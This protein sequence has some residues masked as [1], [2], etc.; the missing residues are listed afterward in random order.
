MATNIALAAVKIAAGVLGS[1][2]AL[3]ADGVESSV[4][5]LSSFAVWN[6]LRIAAWPPDEDHPYGHGKAESIAGLVTALTLMAAAVAIAWESLREIFTPH[7]S[8]APFTLIVLMAVIAIKTALSR[9]VKNVGADIDSSALK[10][11]AA[12][13][14]SD[15]IT[16]AAAFIGIS[17]AI[18]GGPG[19]ESADDWGALLAS[20]VIAFNGVQLIR[21]VLHEIM[22]GSVSPELRAQAILIAASA[23]G[24]V[25]IE[26]CR[27]RKSGLGIL[28]DIHV[29]VDALQTVAQG[30]AIGADAK[31]RL[32]K[33]PLRI[34]DVTVH[35]E[36]ARPTSAG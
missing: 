15:A 30:H 31:H 25:Q 19:Y 35:I 27:M 32:L 7:H 17:I 14:R 1:S 12:H 26:K 5:V 8:P 9:F 23:P 22:D 33:S 36:P 20:I 34:H 29:E 10:G 2:Y 11:D 6:G 18:V 3:I 16:S 24:V 21:P 28:M 13:H 4:D